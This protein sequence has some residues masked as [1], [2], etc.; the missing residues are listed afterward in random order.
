M[1]TAAVVLIAL[2]TTGSIAAAEVFVSADAARDLVSALDRSGL[3]AIAAVDPQ[4]PGMF[5]AALKIA[6]TRLLVIHA[7][8][9]SL[10]A[11]QQRLSAG[12]YR[13][14]YLDLQGT[15]APDGT[16]FVQDAG[17]DGIGPGSS[18][19]DVLYE[20]GQR[21]T[22]FNGDTITQHLTAA[23]YDA[24][25]ASADSRYARLLTLLLAAL[26]ETE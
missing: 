5:V 1:K 17:A 18:G 4:E 7:R 16:F 3:D 10:A 22:I 26:S 2:L 25:L 6:G 8:H 20:D 14:V 13:D 23:E 19:V 9:P 15:P 21:Q 11:I 12:Q 24:K